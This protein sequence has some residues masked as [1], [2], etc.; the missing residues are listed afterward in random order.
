MEILEDLLRHLGKNNQKT[1]GLISQGQNP[2]VLSVWESS[3][4]VSS[5]RREAH[6]GMGASISACRNEGSGGNNW[7]LKV[8][9]SAPPVPLH[10]SP[11][12]TPHSFPLLHQHPVV[13]LGATP[14]ISLTCF[15]DCGWR[16][17]PC[18]RVP[19]GAVD[20]AERGCVL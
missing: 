7:R 19:R 20:K 1:T 12:A 11:P 6:G 4:H 16:A 3:A 9:P 13:D 17:Q 5:W 8:C 14:F 18:K 15:C 10:T 2:P